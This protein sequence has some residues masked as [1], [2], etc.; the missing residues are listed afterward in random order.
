MSNANLSAVAVDDNRLAIIIAVAIAATLDHHCL[1]AIPGPAFPDHFT[2]MVAV[3]MART[4]S[5]TNAVWTDANADSLRTGR[6]R[7][8]NS[9]YRDGNHY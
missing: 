1:V 3:A 2:I 9:R 4:N 5:H 7:R 6:H 8:G